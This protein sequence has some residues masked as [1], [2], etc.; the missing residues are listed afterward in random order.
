MAYVIEAP[1]SSMGDRSAIQ[2]DSTQASLLTLAG[3]MALGAALR[4]AR[5]G[6]QSL[7]HDEAVTVG[8][9]LKPSLGAT[10]HALFNSGEHTPYLYYG[11]AS[12]W[13]HVAGSGAA[14]VRSLSAVFGVLTIPA[15]FAAARAAVSER[16]GLIAA[17][18]VAVDPFL[19]YY[20]QE[21]RSY[22]LFALLTAC[23][24]WA[25]ASALRSP[26]TPALAAWA[27]VGALMLY[28]HYFAILPVA[29]EA[30]WLTALIRPL[31]RPLIALAVPVAAG[32]CLLPLLLHQKSGATIDETTLVRQLP[33]VL[34]QFA[35]GQSLSIRGVYTAT[36]LLGSL[37]FI[38][39]V[40][41][42]WL[43]WR[44]RHRPLFA[45]AT[46]GLLT[47]VLALVTGVFGA[48]VFSARYCISALIALLV[49]LAGLLSL[50]RPRGLGIWVTAS[51]FACGL[52]VCVALAFVPALQR[53]DYRDAA[54]VLGGLPREQ[55]ALVIS[56]GGDDPTL[57]YRAAEQPRSWPRNATPVDEIAVLG[58]D[59]APPAL[60]PLPGFAVFAV[61]ETGT[62]RVTLLVAAV[63]HA[64]SRAELRALAPP[65]HVGTVLLE[66]G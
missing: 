58:A 33:T 12:L 13:T 57:Y 44:L 35:L 48:H 4:F 28:T 9:I 25:F 24:L 18:L 15:A 56:P 31:R 26:S 45:I 43:A 6:H 1:E 64:F 41:M 14:G 19:V 22:A 50:T 47:I 65:A 10:F 51:L 60:L 53:P 46:V 30:A 59:D 23:S 38:A 11:L 66:S 20:S 27:T 61:H 3:L 16:A 40:L 21:A 17:A 49:L 29:L 36:P 5:L 63:P 32:I 34:V 7:G 39:A 62:V 52:A 42:S 37:V 8:Q 2:L 54:A 55:R